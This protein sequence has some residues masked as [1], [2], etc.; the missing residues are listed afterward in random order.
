[1]LVK[2][3][4]ENSNQVRVTVEDSGT[5][6]EPQHVDKIFG[7]FFTTKVDGM[8]NGPVDLPIDH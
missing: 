6:I 7:S 5:G 8:G 3:E 2:S 1:M 4:H